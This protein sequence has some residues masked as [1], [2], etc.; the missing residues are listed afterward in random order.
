[1][2]QRISTIT[3]CKITNVISRG[4]NDIQK[5]LKKKYNILKLIIFL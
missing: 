1:M 4:G 3:N 5:T 2:A